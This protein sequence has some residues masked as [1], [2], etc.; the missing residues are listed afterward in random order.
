LASELPADL[1]GRLEQLAGIAGPLQPHEDPQLTLA[2]VDLARGDAGSA[3][4]RLEQ[5]YRR[6]AHE[7][8]E[9]ALAEVP[10]LL[11]EVELARGHW[12]RAQ[13]LAGEALRTA[14]RLASPF[15]LGP[16]LLAAAMVDAHLGNTEPARSAAVELVELAKRGGVVPVGLEAQAVL[17]FLALSQGDA[18]AAHAE[19]GPLL[20]RL[21]A[22]GVREPTWPW[23]V[24]SE[25]D[26]LVELGQLERAATLAQDL[27]ARDRTLDR[28]LAL[29]T[30]ARARGRICAARGDLEGRWPS[31]AR[32]W[33]SMTGWA[34]RSSEPVPCWRWGWC[35]AAGSRSGPPA[36][37][38]RKPL[39]SSTSWGRACGR[40]GPPR[41]WAGLV[42][43][44]R[45]PVG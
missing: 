2:I 31:C 33:P 35:C 36:R 25:L 20:E 3:A 12:P 39:W 9:P 13:R 8:D 26:A 27:E 41:S 16:A 37:A 10:A 7:G 18:Q 21:G 32:R 45:P 14:R 38:S 23:L 44:R 17:G 5:V 24:W 11:A 19:L 6:A 22:M 28:P 34:G 29:A 15:P 1:P 4:D 30:A 40:P 43:A 42:A